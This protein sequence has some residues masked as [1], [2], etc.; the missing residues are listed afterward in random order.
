M[1]RPKERI[2]K[3]ELKTKNDELS[4]GS[5]VS[6][7]DIPTSLHTFISSQ[8]LPAFTRRGGRQAGVVIKCIFLILNSHIPT[9][10]H[11]ASSRFRD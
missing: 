3:Y 4:N 1:S 11:S 9:Y 8:K 10:L 7:S 2:L 6:L 5:S